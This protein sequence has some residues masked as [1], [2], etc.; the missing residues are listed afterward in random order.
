MTPDWSPDGRQLAFASA[1]TRPTQDHGYDVY[2]HDAATGTARNLTRGQE[3]GDFNLDPAWSPDGRELALVAASGYFADAI[4]VLDLETGESWDFVGAPQAL[5]PTWSPDG[6]RIAFAGSTPT[7]AAIFVVDVQG[8][9]R[10][11]LVEHASQPDWSPDGSRLAYVGGEGDIYVAHADGTQPRPLTRTETAIESEPSWSPDGTRVAFAR[12]LG[13]GLDT[14]WAI[15]V[16]NADGSGE[17]EIVRSKHILSSPVWRPSGGMPTGRPPCF[18]EGS[19]GPDRL[20]GTERGDVVVGAAGADRITGLAARDSLDGGPGADAVDGGAGNDLVIGGGGRDTLAGGDGL[21]TLW[22]RDGWR[23]NVLCGRGKDYLYADFGDVWAA[24]CEAVNR[25][26]SAGASTA[27]DGLLVFSCAGC[28]GSETGARLFTIEARWDAATHAAW[29]RGGIRAAVVA[30]R[31]QDRLHA[32]VQP[33]RARLRPRL[34]SSGRHAPH[35]PGGRHVARVVARRK[36]HRLR[37]GQAWARRRAPGDRPDG[38]PAPPDDR[39]RLPDWSPDGRKI[40]GGSAGDAE[41][42]WVVDADGSRRRPRPRA[43]VGREPRWSRREPSGLRRLR[44]RGLPPSRAAHGSRAPCSASGPSRPTR[45]PDG[46]RLARCALSPS[47][48]TARTSARASSSRS[49]IS[50]RREG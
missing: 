5:A 38:N 39:P 35:P 7:G 23:D 9:S 20:R 50:E 41:R 6:R 34:G 15:V 25:Q 3:W 47:S 44:R 13:T 31:P 21:D 24:D 19:A 27:G 10:R 26:A 1:G 36:A 40:A 48:A 8:G 11:V 32:R 29:N 33:D 12:S 14:R 42:M 46:Y 28:P 49:W 18:R 16:T 43:L 4:V 30:R 17:L 45:A 2:I 37:S 22:A